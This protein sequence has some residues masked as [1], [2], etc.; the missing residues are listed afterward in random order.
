M[1]IIY[2]NIAGLAFEA[3]EEADAIR[4][5]IQEAAI[6]NE[7]VDF[8]GGKTIEWIEITSR[9]PEKDGED[10]GNGNGTIDVPLH[11]RLSTIVAVGA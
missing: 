2:T 1:S 10:G 7:N 8:D 4:E 9:R 6:H 3:Q 11:V 5:D